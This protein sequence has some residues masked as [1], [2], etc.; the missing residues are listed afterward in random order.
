MSLLDVVKSLTLGR[1][2]RER[3]SLWGSRAP[4]LSSSLL[5]TQGTYTSLT[6][7]GGGVETGNRQGAGSSGEFLFYDSASLN[8]PSEVPA[9]TAALCNTLPCVRKRIDADNTNDVNLQQTKGFSNKTTPNLLDNVADRKIEVASC[10]PNAFPFEIR[11]LTTDEHSICTLFQNTTPEIYTDEKISEKDF[12]TDLSFITFE[13][14]TGET[15]LPVTNTS[16]DSCTLVDSERDITNSQPFPIANDTNSVNIIHKIIENTSKISHFAC[17]EKKSGDIHEPCVNETSSNNFKMNIYDSSTKKLVSNNTATTPTAGKSPSSLLTWPTTPNDGH[18]SGVRDGASRVRNTEANDVPTFTDIKETITG[19]VWVRGRKNSRGAVSVTEAADECNNMNKGANKKTFVRAR[20]ARSRSKGRSRK[21][22]HHVSASA[23]ALAAASKN[24]STDQEKESE[25]KNDRDVNGEHPL[26]GIEHTVYAV[27][28][29]QHDVD[30]KVHD[31]KKIMAMANGSPLD[32]TET[33]D[34]APTFDV[35]NEQQ[36]MI[37]R[38]KNSLDKFENF[39]E[40]LPHVSTAAISIRYEFPTLTNCAV[41]NNAGNNSY[42]PLVH[43]KTNC[44]TI[45]S[46]DVSNCHTKTIFADNTMPVVTTCTTKKLSSKDIIHDKQHSISYLQSTLRKLGATL[47]TP[48]RNTV[49]KVIPDT[50]NENIPKKLT[51]FNDDVNHATQQRVSNNIDN[52]CTKSIV[53]DEQLMKGNDSKKET[54]MISLIPP[55]HVI[56]TQ[57]EI[58]ASDNSVTNG[59]NFISNNTNT[60]DN[61]E[62]IGKPSLK[63]SQNLICHSSIL[64]PETAT[65]VTLS[66][67]SSSSSLSSAF[68]D[69]GSSEPLDGSSHGQCIREPNK[70]Q[71]LNNF[72]Q[73]QIRSH[74]SNVDENAVGSLG[75]TVTQGEVD[76]INIVIL[77]NGAHN[78]CLTEN[79]HHVNC[80]STLD[81]TLNYN[82]AVQRDIFVPSLIE[83]NRENKNAAKQSIKR[84]SFKSDMVT[85]NRTGNDAR[86]SVQRSP[87]LGSRKLCCT[88][89]YSSYNS[90]QESENNI[91]PILRNKLC[92]AGISKILNSERRNNFNEAAQFIHKRSIMCDNE[93]LIIGDVPSCTCD[94]NDSIGNPD[95]CNIMLSTDVNVIPPGSYIRYIPNDDIEE[96]RQKILYRKPSLMR[97]RY[98]RRVNSVLSRDTPRINAF[99]RSIRRAKSFK[100]SNERDWDVGEDLQEC[101]NSEQGRTFDVDGCQSYN[102]NE[103]ADTVSAANSC[104]EVEDDSVYQDCG[105]CNLAGVNDVT[106]PESEGVVDYEVPSKRTEIKLV[107]W[108]IKVDNSSIDEEEDFYY[109]SLD[110]YYDDFDRYYQASKLM[111]IQPKGAIQFVDS[112]EIEPDEQNEPPLTG[113][114]RN[115]KDLREIKKLGVK[116]V[117]S[118]WRSNGEKFVKLV[119]NLDKDMKEEKSMNGQRGKKEKKKKN[120][121]SKSS[122]AKHDSD[123]SRK[124]HK[125]KSPKKKELNYL[126]MQEVISQDKISKVF[127]YNFNYAKELE[128]SKISDNLPAKSTLSDSLKINDNQEDYFSQDKNPYCYDVKNNISMTSNSRAEGLLR[129]LEATNSEDED[130]DDSIDKLELFFSGPIPDDDGNNYEYAYQYP[131]HLHQRSSVVFDG[132]DSQGFLKQKYKRKFHRKSMNS[133][134]NYCYDSG[135]NYSEPKPLLSLQ[136]ESTF[137]NLQEDYGRSVPAEQESRLPLQLESTFNDLQENYGAAVSAKPSVDYEEIIQDPSEGLIENVG[138]FVKDYEIAAKRDEMWVE[139]AAQM[140]DVWDSIGLMD[141]R[142]NNSHVPT[143][144]TSASNADAL[145]GIPSATDVDTTCISPS[146]LLYG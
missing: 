125:S 1:R 138:S 71:Q 16:L 128:T 82:P 84:L 123:S 7:P 119:S 12:D 43:P 127:D 61:G 3:V 60:P 22:C 67:S 28:N 77:K 105:D 41:G 70:A 85:Y 95:L 72:K 20:S 50:D 4:H 57:F 110:D 73:D 87:S 81:A 117:D 88:A 52:D 38:E 44:C 53:I 83:I 36:E 76:D 25:D 68:S 79:K 91:S 6:S 115:V 89:S 37:S 49:S 94:I 99:G 11:N 93:E 42:S 13:P 40:T 129:K 78:E 103:S 141:D 32:I 17:T 86:K 130:G 100:E 98:V 102:G 80:S 2:R 64:H 126:K 92:R 48:L 54:L 30:H 59:T 96:I 62:C 9:S 107:K 5:G 14:L 8:L 45:D 113:M 26:H 74:E 109:D 112:A 136:L 120:K 106:A 39:T 34:G 143:E 116:L 31:V 142:R 146:V 33:R 97:S 56:N 63:T 35:N 15:I 144:I 19:V 27:E 101:G 121:R 135:L 18:C 108:V 111:Q 114:P 118:N 29:A 58:D 46:S 23:F 139:V 69:G 131:H 132:G 133:G 65:I 134:Y 104:D 137:S 145:T 10:L 124:E 90:S 140:D 55:Q 47:N 51:Y 21:N 24:R 75:T 122:D 66:T